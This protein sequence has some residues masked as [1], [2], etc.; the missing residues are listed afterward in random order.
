MFIWTIRTYVKNH[1]TYFPSLIQL[2]VCSSVVFQLHKKIEG[3][4]YYSY[5]N[6]SD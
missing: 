3:C 6:Q 4:T 1:E 2:T 5:R